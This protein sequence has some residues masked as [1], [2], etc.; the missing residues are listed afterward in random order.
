ML[1]ASSDDDNACHSLGD[2]MIKGPFLFQCLHNGPVGS[3]IQMQV[4]C[5]WNEVEYAS[6]VSKGRI[7]N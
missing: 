5:S 3:S 4:S 7:S 1:L 2:V 6:R